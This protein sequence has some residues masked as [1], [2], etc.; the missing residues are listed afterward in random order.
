MSI[1]LRAEFASARLGD[2][3][4]NKRLDQI[5]D[6]LAEVPDRSF[7]N[8]A[9][10]DAELEGMYRFLSN[11]RVTLANLLE[12]HIEA[13]VRRCESVP[14]TLVLHDTTEFRFEGVK[15]REG[16]GD[17]PKGQ[18]FFGHFALAV[19]AGE[20]RVVL[21]LVGALTYT[22]SGEG[23]RT[24]S[25][26]DPRYRH[27][28]VRGESA[29]WLDLISEAND[30][31]SQLAPVHVMDREAD[32]FAT[33]SAMTSHDIRFVARMTVQRR[34]KVSRPDRPGT[35]FDVEDLLAR[36]PVIATREVR[37]SRR[38]GTGKWQSTTHP[39]RESRSALLRISA[40]TVDVAPPKK[41]KQQSLRLS[42]VRVVEA[43]AP[44]DAT[45]IEWMLVSSEPVDS[46][47]QVLAIVDM[48]R[49]RWVI[50]EYFKALKTGC[51]IERRQLETMDALLAALGVF[52]PMAARLLALRAH[53]R[54][55]PDAPASTVLDAVELKAL[56]TISK[57]PLSKSPT[58]KEA[59]EALAALGGH[60]TRN[61]VPGWLTLAR[62]YEQLEIAAR[63]VAALLDGDREK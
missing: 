8:A 6:R 30:R 31:I 29:R 37:L 63:V 36:E 55:A 25:G 43:K 47:E 51:A 7:P 15:R 1:D 12:P 16:L 35:F 41:S 28:A 14:T 58:T 49:S 18:G 2:R 59:I 52:A 42:V 26:V 5:V 34:R 20:E 24:L 45:P 56:R 60:L 9:R 17:L 32:D 53:A 27:L 62:G 13:T 3:R 23:R 54:A 46:V 33:F 44:R 22:R 57:K 4:L 48:Y 39:P 19:A 40:A 11:G 38:Q 50:E 10:S 61:G 21:G